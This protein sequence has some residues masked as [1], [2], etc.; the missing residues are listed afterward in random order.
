M[1]EIKKAHTP[2]QRIESIDVLRGTALLGI[3][4]MNANTFAMPLAAYFNPMAYGGQEPLNLGI[5]GALHLLADQKFMALFSLLF[6][7]SVLLIL[8][9]RRRKGKPLARFHYLRNFWLFLIGLAHGILL[10]TGD[11]LMIYAVCAFFLYWF[12]GLSARWSIGLGLAAFWFPALLFVR[13]DAQLFAGIEGFDEFWNA[14]GARL[15]S[16]LAYFRG[17]YQTLLA[18]RLG[19]YG[20]SGAPYPEVAVALL[21]W[22]LPF[23]AMGMM[24]VGMGLYRQGVLSNEKSRSYYQRC[25][26]IGLGLGLPLAGVGLYL[27]HSRDWAA[28][29]VLGAGRVPNLLATPLVAIGYIGLVMLWCRSGV[30]GRLKDRVACVGKMALTNY[31]GQSVIAGLL[32]YG[33]GLGWFGHVNRAQMLIVVV[34]VWGLSLLGSPAWLSKYRYGPLEWLWRSLSYL[35]L[36]PLRHHRQ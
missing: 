10:W 4:L 8:D 6:G 21:I 36:Q 15:A 16:S 3:F 2:D 33:Y 29:W 25:V 22:E 1:T 28:G 24:L 23:R 20:A 12:K 17:N 27:N 13:M 31:V 19:D 26:T 14:S 32:F 30:L 34:F 11:V 9:G 5:H 7:A 18:G 35:R